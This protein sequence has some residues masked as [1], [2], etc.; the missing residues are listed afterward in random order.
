M[1]VMARRIAMMGTQTEAP[2]AAFVAVLR[3]EEAVWEGEAEVVIAADVVDVE[4]E[5]E[6]E[7]EEE[8]EEVVVVVELGWIWLAG[9]ILK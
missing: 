8:E 1:I 4:E 9:R 3:P 7:A 5:E 2:M 6:E